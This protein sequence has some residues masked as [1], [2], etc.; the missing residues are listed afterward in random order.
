MADTNIELKTPDS[1]NDNLIDEF[2]RKITYLRISVTDRC[3][4]RCA[5][6]SPDEKF[7]KIPKENILSLEEI[8]AFSEIAVSLGI[9]KIRLTGGE[10]LLRK[11]LIYLVELL[12]SIQNVMDLAM[13]TNGVLLKQFAGQLKTAGLNRIN[14]S[15]DTLIPEK[16][17][18]ITRENRLHEV[19]E[20][21]NAAQ[22]ANFDSVKINC[23]IIPGVNEDEIEDLQRFC[24]N[25]G[26]D[27]QFINMMDL[28]QKVPIPIQL[29]NIAT[30]PPQCE[31]CNKLRLSCDG[32]LFP[33]LYST[34]GVPIKE[35]R[36]YKEALIKAV[37]LKP[38]SGKKSSFDTMAEI[39]G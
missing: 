12:S 31:G 37:R 6:C 1:K 33:C 14:I 34:I 39:G 7:I 17:Y 16:Y 35:K 28:R 9:T 18:L 19:L 2:N 20:G 13:T 11:N 27:L 3:N 8:Y 22:E 21:I 36:F 23:V 25:L 26:L 32:K 5:Y 4:Q 29:E 24:A 15:L 30:R 38:F 10:P